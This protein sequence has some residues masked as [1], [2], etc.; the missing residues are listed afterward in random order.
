MYINKPTK[1][2]VMPQDTHINTATKSAIAT[3]PFD[4]S[5]SSIPHTGAQSKIVETTINISIT[6]VTLRRSLLYK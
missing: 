2:I 4:Y 3:V 6:M 1:E 5:D